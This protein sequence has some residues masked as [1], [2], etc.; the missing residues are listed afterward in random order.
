MARITE[1]TIIE[2]LRERHSKDVFVA[3]CKDGP[4]QNAAHCI[5]DAWT[6]ARSWAQPTVSA[7]EIKVSRSDFLRDKKWTG[8]LDM[9]NCLSFA[10][11][12]GVIA[13]NEVPEQ[14][15]LVVTSTN[16]TRLYT[17][18][19]APYRDVVI[20]ETVW[21]YVLMCRAK[22]V[23]ELELSRDKRTEWEAWMREKDEKKTLGFNVSRKIR[24]LV[25]ERVESVSCEN[26]RLASEV[27]KVAKYKQELEAAGF[28]PC[29][30]WTFRNRLKDLMARAHGGLPEEFT[31]QLGSTIGMLDR[32]DAMIKKETAFVVPVVPQSQ[33]R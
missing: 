33:P 13:A 18:K 7:Y 19:K 29:E 16:G 8:Y 32:L 10:C 12:P 24:E 15:G 27:A 31:R 11:P 2:L 30:E 14:C 20:P 6:M 22:I 26:C 1:A 21:R 3:H 5:A 28:W 4:S 17:K 23:T 25:F 9:C